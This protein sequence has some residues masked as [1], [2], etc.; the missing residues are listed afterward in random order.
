MEYALHLN[1]KVE[2][3]LSKR[4]RAKFIEAVVK[5]I[6]HQS[7]TQKSQS[8][9]AIIR[10]SIKL[11]FNTLAWSFLQVINLTSFQADAVA[12]ELTSCSLQRLC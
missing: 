3:S 5:L 9:A 6:L 10:N 11:T 7:I 1:S 8:F 12:D 2:S 4:L